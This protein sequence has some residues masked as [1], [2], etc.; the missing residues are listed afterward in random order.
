MFTL[1][2]AAPKLGFHQALIISNVN[3]LF[4]VLTVIKYNRDNF[5]LEN[6]GHGSELGCTVLEYP[7]FSHLYFTSM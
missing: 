6:T 2:T 5:K 4:P 3:I 1:S 7:S